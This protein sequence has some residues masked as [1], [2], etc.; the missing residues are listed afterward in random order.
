MAGQRPNDPTEEECVTGERRDILVA[1]TENNDCRD[2]RPTGRLVVRSDRCLH[3]QGRCCMWYDSRVL[4]L[5]EISA[6]N[7]GIP[8]HEE[9]RQCL[10]ETKR[11]RGCG[12]AADLL[13]S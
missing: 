8:H 7:E 9:G 12:C 13:M 6:W 2:P 3:N 1:W 11:T 4:S 10:L 5:R